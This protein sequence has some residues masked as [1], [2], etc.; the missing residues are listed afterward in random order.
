MTPSTDLARTQSTDR[1][2]VTPTAVAET[3]A[4]N[5]R[6]RLAQNEAPNRA[7]VAIS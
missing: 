6:E 1:D 4:Q 5:L 3:R 7:P 2:P